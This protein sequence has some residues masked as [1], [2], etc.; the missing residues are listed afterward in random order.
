MI[1]K[2]IYITTIAMIVLLGACSNDENLPEVEPEKE[3][4]TMSFSV[5]M[6][7]EGP[8]TRVTLTKD[9]QDI[10]LKWVVGDKIDLAFVQNNR[11]YQ[12][13]V[14]DNYIVT[15]T[16]TS[17]SNDD[18]TA[19]FDIT[20]PSFLSG[21]FTLYGVYGG[22]GM[23]AVLSSTKNRIEPHL[24][25]PENP[26][27]SIFLN[28]TS[29]I[30]SKKDVALYFEQSMNSTDDDV[31]VTFKHVGFLFNL[32]VKNNAGATISNFEPVEILPFPSDDYSDFYW[33]YDGTNSTFNLVD[34]QFSA[35]LNAIGHFRRP[36]NSLTPGQSA[37]SWFWQ[38]AL[39]IK[40]P[41]FKIFMKWAGLN[42][43][44]GT[45]TEKAARTPIAGKSYY[46]Y[47]VW[48]GAELDFTTKEGILL[49]P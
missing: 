47:V 36:V 30:Q 18:R 4:R 25:L 39:G 19:H 7:D 46:L 44:A 48:N 10:K 17:I 32:T 37:T 14:T 43:A 3:A 9:G 22:G 34:K 16:V 49:L 6:P 26:T 41:K 5:N 38:P 42:T 8:D 45:L 1:K 11:I 24:K 12:D 33:F 28:G 31:Q 21:D 40:W 27:Q 29:S 2:I 13:L 15:T 35:S 23:S 20:L